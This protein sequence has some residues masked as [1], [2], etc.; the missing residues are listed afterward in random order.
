MKK[1]AFITLLG[2]SILC[3]SELSE[4]NASSG[5][6][7]DH[8]LREKSVVDM[9]YES[10]VER[11][12]GQYLRSSEEA[13]L[14]LS[15]RAN[16]YFP[17]IEE[18][19][20][21]AGLP[22]ELKYLTLVESRLI[23]SAR[24]RAGASGLWQ[25]MVPTARYC[26]LTV[27]YWV[28]ERLDPERSTDAAIFYL[29][30]LYEQFDDWAL[31]MAAYNA[32]PGRVRKAIRYSGSTEFERVAPFLPRETRQYV[33]RFLA[34]QQYFKAK[35]VRF[36]AP[37]LPN[38]DEWW[39]TT[40]R[41]TAA[42]TLQRLAEQL[43]LNI[44]LLRGLNPAWKRDRLGNS[45]GKYTVRIPQRVLPL[46]CAVHEKEFEAA[47]FEEVESIEG[48]ALIF[49]SAKVQEVNVKLRAMGSLRLI[50]EDLSLNP[51]RIA[52]W[53]QLSIHQD[54]PR[55]TVIR[56]FIPESHD[57]EQRLSWLLHAEEQLPLLPPKEIRVLT[58]VEPD[59]PE[60]SVIAPFY[61]GADLPMGQP[62][63]GGT[64]SAMS[65]DV[66]SEILRRKEKVAIQFSTPSGLAS[67]W[68]RLYPSI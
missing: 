24:S 4:V 64:P 34:A 25:L 3:S 37:Y 66:F 36:A 65:E 1:L 44:Q 21:A 55:G 53:N 35:E 63:G 41:L 49:S 9:V 52:A 56:L 19:L 57:C 5:S 40:V 27:D 48:E 38:P 68:S 31:V 47:R 7:P 18:K 17:M 11:Y 39:T 12:V 54:L 20:D 50:A 60:Q 59:I 61:A 46:W 43:K 28:D 30:D 10:Q 33:P 16:K 51:Y 15:E 8:E 13:T 2:S 26:G 45:N 22:L 32:G 62:F 58:E 29:K 67:A 6:L 14:A 42:T 23:P